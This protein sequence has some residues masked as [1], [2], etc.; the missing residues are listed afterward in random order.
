MCSH[1]RLAGLAAVVLSCLTAK[2][3]NMD[4]LD[5]SHLQNSKTVTVFLGIT[6][7]VQLITGGFKQNTVIYNHKLVIRNGYFLY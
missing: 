4:W 6:S 2:I 3:N 7:V 1:N 5:I